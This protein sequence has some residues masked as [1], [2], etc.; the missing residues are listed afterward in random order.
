[1]HSNKFYIVS[2]LFKLVLAMKISSNVRKPTYLEVLSASLSMDETL[3][4]AKV[5]IYLG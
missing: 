3:S 5:P 1:M 4:K 2:K